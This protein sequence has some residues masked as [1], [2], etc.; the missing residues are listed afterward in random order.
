MLIKD[1]PSISKVVEVAAMTPTNDIPVNATAC[2]PF[3]T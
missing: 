1:E 3:S 2:G